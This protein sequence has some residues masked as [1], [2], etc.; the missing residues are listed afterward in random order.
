MDLIYFIGFITIIGGSYFSIRYAWWRPIVGLDHPRILMYHMIT[1]L[2]PGEKRT[3]LAVTPAMFE[4]QLAWLRRNGWHFATMAELIAP[5]QLPPKTV[6]LTFDDGYQDNYTNAF[7]LLKKYG[8]KGTLYLVIDRHDRHWSL[9]KNP[10]IR[11]ALGSAPKLTDEQM[12]EMV[13]SGVF[14]LGSHTISHINMLQTPAQEKELELIQSKE[15]LQNQFNT[16]VTSFAYPY[17]FYGADDIEL[18]RKAGYDNA[19]TTI[20]GISE[21]IAKERFELKRIKVSGKDNLLAFKMRI[22][23]GKRGLFK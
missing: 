12:Q 21:N 7:P 14:E 19:V 4:R 20:E 1:D 8:A 16:N 15:I 3:G 9:K 23:T 5:E 22:R 11:D 18:V 6:I 17:G 13:D 2:P 10:A